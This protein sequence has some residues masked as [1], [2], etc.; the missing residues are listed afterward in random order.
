MNGTRTARIAALTAALVLGAAL[1]AATLLAS[2]PR[3]G[4]HPDRES[5][6]TDR[7]PVLLRSAEHRTAAVAPRTTPPPTLPEPAPALGLTAAATTVERP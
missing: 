3:D 2:G 5:A 6:L 1:A 4:I 7:A